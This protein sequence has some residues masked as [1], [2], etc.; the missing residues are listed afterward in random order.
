MQQRHRRAHFR[1]WLVLLVLL[2]LGFALGLSL[3]QER[4][5]ETTFPAAARP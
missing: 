2:P 3:R 1:I 5:I 4:P